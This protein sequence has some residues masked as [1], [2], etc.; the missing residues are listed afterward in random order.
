MTR[1]TLSLGALAALAVGGTSGA[2][3]GT[4]CGRPTHGE[5]PSIA[6]RPE[7]MDPTGTTGSPAPDIVDPGNPTSDAGT[8]A[9]PKRGPVAQASEMPTPT[10]QPDVASGTAPD[11][12]PAVEPPT[13]VS[14]APAD[15]GVGDSYA[16]PLPPVPD[17]HLA[18]SRLEPSAEQP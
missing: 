5:M 11:A 16:P 13:N 18:D 2:V 12:R 7:R 3:T 10:F 9:L 8:Q 17:A 6:P 15:A 14:G 4:G 1:L